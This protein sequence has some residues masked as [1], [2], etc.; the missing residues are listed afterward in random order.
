MRGSEPWDRNDVEAW[1]DRFS[2]DCE[3]R[4]YVSDQL[5]DT[6]YRGHE[7]LREFWHAP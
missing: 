6:L 4:A 7:G 3:F 5:E 1:I 2:P